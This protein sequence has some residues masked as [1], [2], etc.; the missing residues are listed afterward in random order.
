MR[1]WLSALLLVGCTPPAGEPDDDDDTTDA[2]AF[3]D[4][5]AYLPV[6]TVAAGLRTPVRGG[7]AA[8]RDLDGDG[9]PELF[10]TDF[11]GSRLYRNR[12]DL[13]FEEWPSQPWLDGP[14][15]YDDWG[16]TFV[17]VD[18]DGDADLFLN[19]G[20]GD[21]LYLLDGETFTE[22][23]A[24]LLPASATFTMSFT[25]FD[26]DGLLDAYATVHGVDELDPP[27]GRDEVGGPDVLYRGVG[28]G[29]F[30]DA[31]HLL[32]P[33]FRD[34]RGF[35]G[36]WS[37]FDHDG[38]P[39]LY[40]VNE[41]PPDQ[42]PNHL[43]RNDGPG[44]DGTLFSVADDDCLCD[45]SVAGMGLAIG[46]YDR[47]GSQDVFLT[48][49]TYPDLDNPGAFRGGEIAQHNDWPL[50]T[51]ATDPAG[52]G[53][54]AL[55]AGRRTISW[56]AEWFDVDHDGWQDL[57]V[58]YGPFPEDPTS[59]QPNALM[60]NRGGTF[61]LW[62]DSGASDEADG[63]AVLPVDLDGD[64]CLDLVV[65]NTDGA[66]GLFRH[67]CEAV[68]EWIELD[69]VA[70]TGPRD[71]PGAVAIV[72]ADG[73][74]QRHE[75]LIGA[76]HSGPSRILHVGLGAAD[77]AHVEVHWPGGAITE[78]DLSAGERHRIVEP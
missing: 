75:V 47:D 50:F 33:S 9:L 72:T 20:R 5:P 1:L 49:I 3:E 32:P 71:A 76:V 48:N 22:H 40:L 35:S 25:D 44:P 29:R 58:A 13:T 52:L 36:R 51:D 67:R 6:D 69:L 56:G 31:S 21:V 10:I 8:V 55:E 16:A 14:G 68:G 78:D 42:D 66:T 17:D 18:D 59:T 43:L 15:P 39:D 70:T 11:D 64:G 65:G 46:D 41:Q 7:G 73:V 4:Q 19:G 2:S 37:D 74:V 62:E 30:E 38:D 24:G 57:Y 34:G 53:I 60:R 54:G 28:A 27:G 23:D 45:H 26:A 12:G 77:E 61:E 63:R